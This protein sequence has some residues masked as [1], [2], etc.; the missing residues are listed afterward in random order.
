[1]LP[2]SFKFVAASAATQ[3]K[4][5]LYRFKP[6][7]TTASPNWDGAGGN[8]EAAEVASPYTDKSFWADRYALCEL[9]F[10]KES[11]EELTINDAIAAISKR[12]N[13]VTTPLVGMDGT[14]KEYINDGD[15]G[16]N[17]IVGVQALRDGKIVDE[18]PSDGITQLRQFF[19]VKETIYVHSEFL[20]L[21]DISK[22]VV[23]NFS[24]TQAT[25]S[26]YQ[27]IELSLL[28]DGDYN[29]YSTEYK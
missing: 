12:K 26:N 23:Q 14:V 4:G 2:I 27:P 19:D 29:V 7:R 18:Y 6:S 11:G 21:F 15:Y 9:I 28:S 24:V 3:L 20:E 8:I 17:L 25:E 1:M 13:I 10:R 22:V 16:I 5:Y